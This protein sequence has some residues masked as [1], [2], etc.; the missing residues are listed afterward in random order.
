VCLP[1]CPPP[2]LFLQCPQIYHLGTKT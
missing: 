1:A 2:Q